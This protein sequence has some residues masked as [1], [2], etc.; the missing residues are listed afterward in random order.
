MGG[1]MESLTNFNGD[2]TKTLALKLNKRTLVLF[3]I[4][5]STMISGISVAESTTYTDSLSTL[6]CNEKGGKSSW[7]GDGSCDDINNNYFCKFDG[8]DCCGPNVRKNFCMECKCLETTCTVNSD[9]GK[10]SCENPQK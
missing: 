3:F 10:V 1:D 2:V 7:I 6:L 4:T 5:L 9:T 8:G